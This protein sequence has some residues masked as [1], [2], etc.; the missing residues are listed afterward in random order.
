MKNLS[1]NMEDSMIP[2]GHGYEATALVVSYHHEIAFEQM[3]GKIHLDL[4]GHNK[5]GD[6]NV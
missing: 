5:M 6:E 3:A 4:I 2:V 1:S